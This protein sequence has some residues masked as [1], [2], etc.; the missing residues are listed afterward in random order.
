MISEEEA[1]DLLGNCPKNTILISHS[2]PKGILDVSSN[3]QHLGSIAV[4][5]TIE[6]KS[7]RLVVCGHIHESCGKIEKYGSTVVVNA[8]PRGMYYEL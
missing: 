8:G 4:K 7:P 5:E 3:G 6:K 2:P 1:A